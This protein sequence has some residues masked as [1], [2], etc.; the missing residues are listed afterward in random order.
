M[1]V[2]KT[3]DYDFADARHLAVARDFVPG[4]KI[5]LWSFS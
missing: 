2:H 3:V 1:V 5:I 4:E